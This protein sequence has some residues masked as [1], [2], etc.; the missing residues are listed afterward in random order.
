MVSR[1]INLA[2]NPTR[3]I[4]QIAREYE[5]RG[6]T[7]SRRPLLRDLLPDAPAEFRPDLVARGR[8]ENVVVEVKS[9]SEPLHRREWS[10]LEP[11]VAAHP[12]WRFELVLMPPV[13]EDVLEGAARFSVEDVESV[14]DEASDLIRTG[15]VE[16]GLL[17][18]WSAV[19][20]MLRLLSDH[21]ELSGP[22]IAHPRRLLEALAVEGVLDPEE[23][24]ALAATMALRNSAAHGFIPNKIDPLVAE[25]TFA[26]AKR[27]ASREFASS[28]AT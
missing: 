11:L 26:T 4:D 16:A 8:G 5:G 27:I 25:Q 24:E 2:P 20:G 14:L 7:V 15:Y 10:E 21:N 1:P 23:H 9:R 17:R 12:D 3:K 19:E 6:Y 13:E 28:A 18:G 22:G